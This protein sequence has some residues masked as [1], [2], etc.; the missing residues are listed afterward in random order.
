MNQI[1]P[2]NHADHDPVTGAHKS[3]A[4][5]IRDLIT[6][7]KILL[8]SEIDYYRARL[9]YSKATAKWAVLYAALAL[10][11]LFGAVT[12]LI[13]G[14]LLIVAEYLGAPWATIIV[15]ISF[16]GA[17]FGFALLSRKRSKLLSFSNEFAD[18]ND[19]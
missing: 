7:S 4:D 2:E 18:S 5:T 13:L 10:F 15:T 8:T 19:D 6:D 9:D 1:E 11:G 12:A 3:P 14:L 17:A 16:V